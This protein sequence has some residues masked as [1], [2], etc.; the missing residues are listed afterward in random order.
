M[1]TIKSV[2]QEMIRRADYMV[3]TRYKEVHRLGEGLFVGCVQ[4]LQPRLDA[5]SCLVHL[6]DVSLHAPATGSTF[7]GKSQH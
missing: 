6:I 5:M 2:H 3:W 7:Q 1:D 4:S